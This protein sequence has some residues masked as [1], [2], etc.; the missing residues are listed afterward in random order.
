MPTK[1]NILA[2]PGTVVPEIVVVAQCLWVGEGI[3]GACIQNVRVVWE[4][5]KN[6]L[7][8]LLS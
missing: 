8:L 3:R 2:V 5:R 6:F 4:F 1:L 7:L